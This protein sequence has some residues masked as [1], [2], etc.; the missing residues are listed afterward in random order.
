MSDKK[1]V[2]SASGRSKLPYAIGKVDSESVAFTFDGQQYEVKLSVEM[3]TYLLDGG[4][5]TRISADG[6]GKKGKA[7][8]SMVAK[9]EA[10]Q[11]GV[12]GRV[13]FDS[14][15]L[16]KE[17]AKAELTDI[18]KLQGRIASAPKSKQGKLA[19]AIGVRAAELLTPAEEVK[20]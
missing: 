19:M 18:A 10:L 5:R 20:K 2:G 4:L 17:I 14:E 13:G 1:Q 3:L 7:M 16:L 9:C 12:V 11:K 8:A 6:A 15:A